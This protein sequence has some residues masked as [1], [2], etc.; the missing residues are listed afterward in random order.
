[1]RLPCITSPLVLTAHHPGYSFAPVKLTADRRQPAWAQ[2][3]AKR[4]LCTSAV[5]SMS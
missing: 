5:E 3:N 4:L 2:F 1:M